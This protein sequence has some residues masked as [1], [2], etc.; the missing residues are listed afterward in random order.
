MSRSAFASSANSVLSSAV[1]NSLKFLEQDGI[2]SPSF[3]D[4][5]IIAAQ[6]FI[7]LP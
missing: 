3:H 4:F 5:A 6:S 2:A 1:C 7:A